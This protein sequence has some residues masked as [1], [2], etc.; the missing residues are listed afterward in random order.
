ME[1]KEVQSRCVQYVRSDDGFFCQLGSEKD[2]RSEW[3][4]GVSNV[5]GWENIGRINISGTFILT[6]LLHLHYSISVSTRH[7]IQEQNSV[8]WQTSIIVV[9]TTV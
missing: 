7:A 8:L 5:V 6:S 2:G 4:L 3:V 9:K 1:R